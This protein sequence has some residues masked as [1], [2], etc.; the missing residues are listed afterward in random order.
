M[1]KLQL[2]VIDMGDACV[3]KVEKGDKSWLKYRDDHIATSAFQMVTGDLRVFRFDTELSRFR[4]FTDL[5]AAIE[6]EV[7]KPLPRIERTVG[8]CMFAYDLHLG[9][10]QDCPEKRFGL[11]YD[12]YDAL[13]KLAGKPLPIYEG[14]TWKRVATGKHSNNEGMPDIWRF[15]K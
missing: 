3:V 7:E 15:T 13:T 9:R 4:S 5:R 14:G 12:D 1:N 11:M 2:L 10:V 8:G 6:A